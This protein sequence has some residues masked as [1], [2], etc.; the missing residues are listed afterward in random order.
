MEL[1][2]KNNTKCIDLTLAI[3]DIAAT[4]GGMIPLSGT[5]KVSAEK[6]QLHTSTV[7]LSIHSATHI[8]LPWQIEWSSVKQDK[9]E[10]VG[11]FP[12]LFHNVDQLEKR[13]DEIV[14]SKKKE[15][16]D[17]YLVPRSL[18]AVI[19]DFTDRLERIEPFLIR[20][21]SGTVHPFLRSDLS[22]NEVQDLFSRL[23]IT[24]DELEPRLA[25]ARMKHPEETIVVIKTGWM[26]EFK[27]AGR[28]RNLSNPAFEGW[29]AFLT[30]PY[31][32]L[33]AIALLNDKGVLGV[34]SDTVSLENLLYAVD[35]MSP[36]SLPSI[37][38][39]AKDTA[40]TPCGPLHLSFLSRRKYIIESMAP[41]TEVSTSKTGL[42]RGTLHIIP[43]DM[44]VDDGFIARI[45]FEKR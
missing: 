33:D 34:G 45:M 1:Q 31:L 35:T 14:D 42:V 44:G 9:H 12:V 28:L 36:H 5:Q 39:L 3:D 30:Y 19:F 15:I 29:H 27:P 6:Y 17:W 20:D 4:R 26:E 10:I 16:Q 8:D 41:L 43:M 25:K 40:R 2:V 21:K 11:Q 7:T 24:G 37:I 23:R 38:D 18:E 22:T 32:E 13:A